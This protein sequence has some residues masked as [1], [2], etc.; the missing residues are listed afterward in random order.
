MCIDKALNGVH[1]AKA[2]ASRPSDLDAIRALIKSKPGG[3]E[4]LDSTVKRHLS[5]WFEGKGAV[6]SAERVER[7][8]DRHQTG[9][10]SGG[11]E[12]M[13]ISPPVLLPLISNSY[14]E[15]RGVETLQLGHRCTVTGR[16]AGVV[17]FVGTV[18]ETMRIGVLLDNPT[19]LNDGTL[20][21]T[22]YFECPNGHGVF[23]KPENVLP[24]GELV[25][26]SDVLGTFQGQ[27][28]SSGTMPESDND[29]Q[30]GFGF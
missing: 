15:S 8:G 9:D 18:K 2:T 13:A 12:R 27:R 28:T 30:F 11:S 1:S 20:G 3:F 5:H 10:W 23:A 6:R 17:R 4:V 16:G 21:G 24:V 26:V 14:N 7:S 22:R 19:G 25:D 29:T